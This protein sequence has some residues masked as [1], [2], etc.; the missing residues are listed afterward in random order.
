M[1][2]S[3]WSSDVCSSDLVTVIDQGAH[4]A[5]IRENGLKLIWEDG[6]E[7]QAKVRAVGS[8]EEAGRQDLVILALKAHYL[9]SV[10]AKIPSL[11][12]PDTMAMTVQNGLPWWHFQT[13]CGAF[14]GRR[15]QT[16]DPNG[17]LA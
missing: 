9:A 3:D 12:G 5:A 16:I 13:H 8:F 10:A 7:H 1:R 4:L 2:I 6:S 14:D 15:L 17:G 11:S